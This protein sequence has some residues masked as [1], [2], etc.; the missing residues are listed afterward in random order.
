[1]DLLTADL[2]LFDIRG[3]QLLVNGDFVLTNSPMSVIRDRQ[4]HST[5][6]SPT[7]GMNEN[8]YWMLLFNY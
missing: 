8:I 1:M 3:H 4:I 5:L 2:Q 7:F 6:A